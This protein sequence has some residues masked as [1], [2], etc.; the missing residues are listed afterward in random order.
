MG[1][2]LAPL[3]EDRLIGLL[4]A[5]VRRLFLAWGSGCFLGASPC[6]SG[7]ER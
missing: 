5:R 2:G 3:G 6:W 4:V 1:R 7:G